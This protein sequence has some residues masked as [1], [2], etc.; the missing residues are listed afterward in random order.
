MLIAD[1]DAKIQLHIMSY[2]FYTIGLSIVSPINVDSENENKTEKKNQNHFTL[3]QVVVIFLL[4]LHQ[5][6]HKSILL[7]ILPFHFNAMIRFYPPSN[8]SFIH[9]PQ[10]KHKCKFTFTESIINKISNND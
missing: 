1:C 9:A 4:C 5:H 3:I 2:G 6:P 10:L 8:V 7:A